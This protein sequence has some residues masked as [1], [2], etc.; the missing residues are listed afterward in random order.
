[1]L[2]RPVVTIVDAVDAVGVTVHS[3]LSD[4]LR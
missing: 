2:A 3:L 1:M 4:T